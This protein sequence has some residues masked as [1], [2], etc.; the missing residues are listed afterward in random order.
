MWWKLTEALLKWFQ[1]RIINKYLKR[2]Y[3]TLSNETNTALILLFL[4]NLFI[5][6]SP[7]KEG[8][9]FLLSDPFPQVIK[10]VCHVTTFT[11]NSRVYLSS[12]LLSD[13]LCL[14]DGEM[15]LER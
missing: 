8:L 14:K 11:H 5:Y 9:I 3:L 15:E 1:S 13:H 4:W 7:L 12:V 6:S 2:Q 10:D